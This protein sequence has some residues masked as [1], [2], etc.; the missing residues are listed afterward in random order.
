MA[1]A[2]ESHWVITFETVQ[3][4]EAMRVRFDTSPFAKKCSFSMSRIVG[5][6][7]VC[8]FV[9]ILGKQALQKKCLQTFSDYGAFKRYVIT[10]NAGQLS[11]FRNSGIPEKWNTCVLGHYRTGPLGLYGL[12]G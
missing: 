11:R 4:P 3:D 12:W 10:Q 1:G 6:N 8:S 2:A 7:L 5:S 9:S